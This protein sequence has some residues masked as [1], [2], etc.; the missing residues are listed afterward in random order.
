MRKKS[1]DPIE[2][3][4]FFQRDVLNK[5]PTI[6]AMID[7]V[8]MMRFKIRPI[9]G[10]ISQLDIKNEH[11]IEILWSLGKLDEFYNAQIRKL[12]EKQKTVIFPLFDG[13][14]QKF[15]KELNDINLKQE[16][17]NDIPNGFEIEI[18]KERQIKPN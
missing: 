10:D 6:T 7:D 8:R 16:H 2:K 4:T 3:L 5:K 14:Y 12:P 18:F 15:Q 11:F 13:M 17:I 1:I 9:Q